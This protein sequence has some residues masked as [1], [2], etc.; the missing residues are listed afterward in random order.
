MAELHGYYESLP[1][2]HLQ[3][4][5]GAGG[6][7]SAVALMIMRDRKATRDAASVQ[8]V[9]PTTVAE[10]LTAPQDAGL[11][12]VVRMANGRFPIGRVSPRYPNPN[13]VPP[14]Y[15]PPQFMVRRPV[16]LDP[17]MQEPP[18]SLTAMDKIN[19]RRRMERARKPPPIIGPGPAS[20]PYAPELGDIPFVDR[21]SIANRAIDEGNYED[22]SD[23]LDAARIEA[24]EIARR[25]GPYTPPSSAAVP[26]R[27]RQRHEAR[28]LADQQSAFVERNA[29]AFAGAPQTTPVP[30]AG[31]PYPGELGSVPAGYEEMIARQNDAERLRAARAA[32]EVERQQ[33][34]LIP[35]AFPGAPPPELGVGGSETGRGGIFAR[36]AGTVHRASGGPAELNR[37]AKGLPPSTATHAEYER[38]VDRLKTTADPSLGLVPGAT[39]PPAYADQ[40][41][42]V[43]SPLVANTKASPAAPKQPPEPA[44]KKADGDSNAAAPVAE[45][46][47]ALVDRLKRQFASGPSEN[48]RA[49]YFK[50]IEEKLAA[51]QGSS[52]DDAGTALLRA[53]L[54]MME[55]GG[56]GVSTAS[57]IGAGGLAGLDAYDKQKAASKADALK[58][59]GIESEIAGARSSQDLANRKIDLQQ[60]EIEL[61]ADRATRQL[62]LKGEELGINRRLVDAKVADLNKPDTFKWY[63]SLS[64]AQREIVNPILRKSSSSL[65]DD[66]GKGAIDLLDNMEWRTDFVRSFKEN[67]KREPTMSDIITAARSHSAS[68]F[69]GARSTVPKDPGSIRR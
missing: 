45:S 39:P 69:I 51:L 31:L 61:D 42:P 23:P 9:E 44:E 24:W 62:D 32:E 63:M 59:L 16:Q 37:R 29:N 53:G 43:S 64:P 30:G 47:E 19:F 65:A 60:L 8:N 48:Q 36:L 6:P 1:D 49:D 28:Q 52:N 67:N 40:L 57:A 12:G 54:A 66:I 27:A 68:L 17:A 14:V 2:Q 34:A 33:A 20:I 25:E 26:G 18:T 4:I 58:M 22:I 11:G 10:D 35:N 38:A 7:E 21:K 50:G 41:D 46:R 3:K 13:R 5:V 15:I 56:K 55:A